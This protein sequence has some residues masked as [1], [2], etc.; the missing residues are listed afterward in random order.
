MNITKE[1]IIILAIVLLVLGPRR[2]AGLGSVLGK[3]I[4]DFRK[5]MTDPDDDRPAP[6][7]PTDSVIH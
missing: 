5:S 1:L 7:R 6:P 4:R 2:L 3:T